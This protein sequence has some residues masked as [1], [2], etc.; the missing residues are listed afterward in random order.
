M[1]IYLYERIDLS[2]AYIQQLSIFYSSDF[3]IPNSRFRVSNK[4]TVCLMLVRVFSDVLVAFL[5][6]DI[7]H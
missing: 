7:C 4:R 2:H 6:F 3:C 1:Q 5:Y